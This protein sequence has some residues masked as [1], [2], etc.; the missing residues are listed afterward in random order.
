MEASGTRDAKGRGRH[1]QV[2]PASAVIGTCVHTRWCQLF[3][4]HEKVCVAH[5]TRACVGGLCWG[6]QARHTGWGQQ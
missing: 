3:V 6:C 2:L 5:Q 1:G 4:M